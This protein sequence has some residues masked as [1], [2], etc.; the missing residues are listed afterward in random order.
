MTK[1]KD[2][3][4]ETEI[5]IDKAEIGDKVPLLFPYLK[6]VQFSY[7]KGYGYSWT[8]FTR[9]CAGMYHFPMRNCT[10]V[11]HFSTLKNA[12]RNFKRAFKT[13]F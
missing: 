8:G 7:T 6:A 5:L 12:K 1:Q 2:E 4:T 9:Q 11:K 3:K 10:K 13:Q